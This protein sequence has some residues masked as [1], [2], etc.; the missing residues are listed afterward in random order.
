MSVYY[1]TSSRRLLKTG[2]DKSKMPFAKS[3]AKS[4]YE[5]IASSDRK[6]KSDVQDSFSHAYDNS[7]VAYSRNNGVDKKRVD[8]FF[9]DS[10][11]S[12]AFKD[13]TIKNLVRNKDAR[14][15]AFYVAISDFLLAIEKKDF[16]FKKNARNLFFHIFRQKCKTELTKLEAGKSIA[17]NF[18]D[19]RIDQL[20]EDV[21]VAYFSDDPPFESY[22]LEALIK[23]FPEE[24]KLLN[25][26]RQGYTYDHLAII[27]KT[28]PQAMRQRVYTTRKKLIKY[29]MDNCK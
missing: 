9:Y 24:M 3:I 5:A 19:V 16:K 10:L 2:F 27:Y 20:S 4:E 13:A 8:Q 12:M 22:H 1:Y 15:E 26:I 6:S 11:K 17:S 23:K 18:A 14:K 28:T 25:M 21:G 7:L 29:Y